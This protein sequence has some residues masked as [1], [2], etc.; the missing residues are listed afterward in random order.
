MD[1]IKQ[2][3][4]QGKSPLNQCIAIVGYA[5]RGAENPLS[6]ILGHLRVAAI[7]STVIGIIP[8]LSFGWAMA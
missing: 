4:R 6:P 2:E 5:T 3:R 7:V 1:T 8:A